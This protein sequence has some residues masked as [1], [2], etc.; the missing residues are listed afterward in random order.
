M[1]ET[2]GKAV[3]EGIPEEAREQIKEQILQQVGHSEEI[4]QSTQQFID[5][6][7]NETNIW[8]LR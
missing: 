6:L 7:N 1:L 8:V 2:M 5:A 4:E 3:I